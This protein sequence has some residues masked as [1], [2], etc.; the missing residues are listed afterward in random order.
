MKRKKKPL[1]LDVMLNDSFV[2]QLEYDRKGILEITDKKVKEY[3]D[4]NVLEE[5]VLEKRPTLK[6]KPFIVLQSKQ[7]VL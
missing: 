7:K 2:C 1:L 4:Y 3:Y 6:N 5:F